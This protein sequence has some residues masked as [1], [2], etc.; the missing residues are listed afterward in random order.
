MFTWGR[1]T[2]LLACDL[3]VFFLL[4]AGLNFELAHGGPE[5][6]VA[7]LITA[8]FP[9]QYHAGWQFPVAIILGL[10]LAGTYRRADARR[11]VGAVLAGVSLGAALCLWQSAWV[12]G[13]TR[14][15]VQFVAAVAF[16]WL[17]LVAGRLVVDLI[18]ARAWPKQR[19]AERVLFVGD[20]S[21]PEAQRISSNLLASGG[22]VS[23]G[24]VD[25]A[26]AGRNGTSYEMDYWDALHRVSADTVVVFGNLQDEVFHSVVEAS[27]AAGCRI[28]AVPRSQGIAKLRHGV[29]WHRGLPFIELTVPSLRAQQMLVKR[30]IDL[31]G[32][33]IGLLVSAPLFALIALAIRLDSPGPVFFS[34]ERV[35]LGGRV[36]RF[37]KFRTMREGA[38]GEKASMAHLNHTGDPRLFK[39]PNDPR[40]TRVGAL[41]RPW[42]LDELPQLWNVLVGDMALVGP[43]P[44]FESDLEAYRDHH[45]SR[46]GAKPGITGM[47][48]VNGRSDVVDFEEVVRLD[49]QYIDQWSLSLDFQIM[50][51]TVPAVFRRTG[52]F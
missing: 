1:I 19:R 46:L 29:A 18:V 23:L 41:L 22:M 32:A 36:F 49:R 3:G 5:S 8:L 15:A 2:T 48:Q 11:D 27:T 28:L 33:S 6:A 39:I 51:Q 4:R 20:P 7:P 30:V 43:R 10:I 25:G 42:S 35:G 44:F 40:V 13:G 17:P 47:W 38:D 21:D 31:L 34:Q 12:I 14:V 52:A 50:A 9:P 45:F 37:H 26:L 16:L 24:W